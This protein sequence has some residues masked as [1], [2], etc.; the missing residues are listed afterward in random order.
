[1]IIQII[2]KLVT[3]PREKDTTVS[4]DIFMKKACKLNL[5]KVYSSIFYARFIGLF[6]G[7]FQFIYWICVLIIDKLTVHW[8]DN[9]V[10]SKILA[11]VL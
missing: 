9:S 3:W 5:N 7:L 6:K 8:V 4:I 10:P 1:M 11:L 2:P